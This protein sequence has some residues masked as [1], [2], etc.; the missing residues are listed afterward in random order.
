VKD[1]PFIKYHFVLCF[2]VLTDAHQP[3]AGQSAQ[4]AAQGKTP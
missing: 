4:P 2:I 1:D 3:L